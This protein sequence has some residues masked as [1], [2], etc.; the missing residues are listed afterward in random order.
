MAQTLMSGHRRALK[1]L[2]DVMAGSGSAEERLD[3]IVKVVAADMIAEVCSVY[4]MRAGQVLELF[5]T[6]GLNPDA[7]HRTR[8]RTGEGLVGTVAARARS[9]N[10]SE[11]RSH[12][13]FS[14]RPETGEEAYHSLLGVPVIRGGRVRGVLVI[15]NKA[16][17]HY[18]DEEVEALEVISVVVAEL[19]AG[20]KLVS[21]IETTTTQGNAILPTRLEGVQINGGLAMGEAVLHLP[22]ISVPRMFAEDPDHEQDRLAEAVSSM[23]SALDDMLETTE[24]ASGGE[25]QDVLQAYRQIAEDRGWLRRIR[26]A[27]DGGLTAEAAVQKVMDDTRARMGLVVDPYLS[28]RVHDLEDLGHRLMQHLSGEISAATT[29]GLPDNVVLL[30][31]NMGPAELLDYE[32]SRVRALVLEEGSPTAHVAI[33]ARALNI[34]VIGMVK[35]VLSQIDPLD[36][37]IVDGENAQIFVRPGEDIQQ[38]AIATM[39]LRQRRRA[40]HA[41]MRDI[42]AITRDRVGISLNLNAGLL[43][44]VQSLQESGADGVGLY[45]TEIPFMVRSAFPGV[46][47]QTELYA[48]VLDQAAGKTVTF[49]TLDIGGDKQLPYFREYIDQNPAMGWRSIRVGL[50]R[51]GMLRQQLRAMIRA[52]AGRELSVMFPMIAEVAEFEAAKHLLDIELARARARGAALPGRLRIGAMMEVPG[53]MWQLD[54]LLPL[55][56]FLSVGSNDLFQFMFASDRGNP[57]VADRYDVLAPGL[58]K[59]LQT[60]VERCDD[61]GVPI[62]LCGEMAGRPIE[63]MALIGLGFRDI[64]MPPA[65]IGAVKSMVQSLS[66]DSLRGY[67]ATLL[68]LPDHSLR[69]KLSAYARDHGVDIEGP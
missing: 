43:M 42:P 23:H 67:L 32:P 49:R 35:G 10:L 34:P 4:I 53:L 8:L 46:E 13:Q 68:D 26:E 21:P 63:A 64:S 36:P 55:V 48:N 47:A 3:E 29:E 24:I 45:R 65:S 62:S 33:V 14:Y 20:G 11:A 2:R 57:R 22:R 61:G 15:Q 59:L 18:S 1:R 66:V 37:V 38:I 25:H 51:P 19:I 30:A 6:Q 27:I 5:A 28:E 41:A 60:L 7:V 40:E 56:D 39:D 50:D 16:R 9:L 44:D 52:A 12:P 54:A 69:Q 17:R 31:R 58:L